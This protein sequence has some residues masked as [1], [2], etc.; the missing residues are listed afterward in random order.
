M[1]VARGVD[2][3]AANAKFKP[4]KAKAL[5]VL[6][7]KSAQNIC[8]SICLRVCV[9]T[10]CYDFVIPSLCVTL[11]HFFPVSHSLPFDCQPCCWVSF[12]ITK[13]TLRV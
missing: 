13:L 7:G 11:S 1:C 12:V 3:E 9:R 8:E 6:D 10:M 4:A 5:K 2:M